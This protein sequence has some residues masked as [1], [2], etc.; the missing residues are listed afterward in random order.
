[1]PC[2]LVCLIELEGYPI[3]CFHLT[4]LTETA[5]VQSHATEC[6]TS[7]DLVKALLPGMLKLTQ[8]VV[9]SELCCTQQQCQSLMNTAQCSLFSLLTRDHCFFFRFVP[10]RAL[11]D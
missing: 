4:R 9:E 2:D 10:G 6:P 1:M 3:L 8:T 5:A 11:H 7:A